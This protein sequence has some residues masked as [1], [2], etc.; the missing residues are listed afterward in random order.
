[1]RLYG[2]IVGLS[3]SLMG[4]SGGSV[5]NII[6]T[7]HGKTIHQAVATSAAL[8]IWISITGAIGYVLAG[9]PHQPQLPFGSLGFVS[10]VGVLVMAPVSSLTAP[11]GARLA[12]VLSRRRLE[13]G[14]G[15]FLLLASVRFLA[16]LIA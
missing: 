7:L 13:I 3:G 14:F 15:I 5:S 11:Y 6:L 9:L 16:S 12:H 4:V 1:M 2:L 8:G 10:L